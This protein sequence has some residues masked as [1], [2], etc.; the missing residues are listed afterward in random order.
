M[1][2]TWNENPMATKIELDEREQAEFKLKIRL[3]ILEE[4]FSEA[5]F[6]IDEHH[7][8]FCNKHNPAGFTLEQGL[9]DARQALSLQWLYDEGEYKGKGLT[10][11]TEELFGYYLNELSS[12]H[13]GDCTCVPASCC[14]CAAEGFLGIDTIEGIS[15]SMGNKISS[16]FCYKDGDEWK[17]RNGREV[18]K[19]LR[20]YEPKFDPKGSWGPDGEA[21]FN[22]YIPKW[23]EEAKKSYDWLVEYY[24]SHPELTGLLSDEPV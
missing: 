19:E 11:R 20:T 13:V 12:E 5:H 9:A 15:K 8:A 18:L 14:K 4:R 2:I 6:D 21:R 16:A 17:S 1:K 7:I 22:S 23:K 10:A 24:R 3:H